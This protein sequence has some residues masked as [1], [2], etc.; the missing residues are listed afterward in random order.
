MCERG[1]KEEVILSV[2]GDTRG[3][4]RKTPRGREKG[5]GRRCE[6]EGMREPP[7]LPK[8]PYQAALLELDPSL[9]HHL[10]AEKH[11]CA[12]ERSEEDRES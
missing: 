12:S 5:K 7:K 6:G 10:R 8:P 1:L 11:S 9:V 2:L 3:L 4:V